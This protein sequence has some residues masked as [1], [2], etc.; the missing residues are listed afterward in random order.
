MTTTTTAEQGTGTGDTMVVRWTR[1][2]GPCTGLETTWAL[3]DGDGDVV[4]AYR[5]G[6]DCVSIDGREWEHQWTAANCPADVQAEA[7]TATRLYGWA[8]SKAVLRVLRGQQDG[9]LGGVCPEEYVVLYAH[10]WSG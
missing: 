10:H 7:R 2:F 4:A 1:A 3:L 8:A 5:L 6:W 9:L